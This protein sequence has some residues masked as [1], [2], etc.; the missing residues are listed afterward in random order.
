M[1]SF[2][3]NTKQAVEAIINDSRSHIGENENTQVSVSYLQYPVFNY[4]VYANK[5]YWIN[6]V[7]Y[8]ETEFRNGSDYFLEDECHPSP[9]FTRENYKSIWN[10]NYQ[11]VFRREP[12]L[13]SQLL[14]S[15][16]KITFEEEDGRPKA[17]GHSGRYSEVTSPQLMYSRA[18]SDT[19]KD[20]LRAGTIIQY[21]TYLLSKSNHTQAVIVFNVQREGVSIVW[22]GIY[23]AWFLHDE[24]KWN[25]MRHL[26]VL[27]NDLLPGDVVVSYLLNDGKTEIDI[28]D[29]SVNYFV[30]ESVKK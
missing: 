29:F 2:N 8:G 22:T 18:F 17:I 19:L 12:A 6:F 13:N 28:D 26:F 3:G 25:S 23:A 1:W 15:L 10:V 4:Y 27:E 30:R 11:E 24:N 9:N 14:H 7:P 5:A 21:H 16:G 20:T